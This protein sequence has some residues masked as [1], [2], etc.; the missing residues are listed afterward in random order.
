MENSS[1]AIRKLHLAAQYLFD[2]HF[3]WPKTIAAIY[4]SVAASILGLGI[5]YCHHDTNQRVLHG[6]ELVAA[7]KAYDAVETADSLAEDFTEGSTARVVSAAKAAEAVRAFTASES[8][9]EGKRAAIVLTYY[10]DA[11]VALPLIDQVCSHKRMEAHQTEDAYMAGDPSKPVTDTG[12]LRVEVDYQVCVTGRARTQDE[13]Q[14]CSAEALSYIAPSRQ[15]P[16]DSCIYRH[17]T[18]PVV[19]RY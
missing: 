6:Q 15:P 12:L 9:A 17:D 8:S 7:S 14:A 18:I 1:E 10:L 4:L 19:R 3:V 13:T 5:W 2:L 16:T 11:V